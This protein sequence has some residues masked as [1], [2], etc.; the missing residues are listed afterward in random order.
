MCTYIMTLAKGKAIDVTYIAIAYT[1]TNIQLT[2]RCNM[3]FPL[4]SARKSFSDY[5]KE[6]SVMTVIKSCC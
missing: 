3:Y 6:H 2:D 5:R 1:E 4:F